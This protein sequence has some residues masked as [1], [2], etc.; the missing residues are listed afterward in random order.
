MDL[1]NLLDYLSDFIDFLIHKIKHF[2]MQ[3]TLNLL[4]LI[5]LG[6]FHFLIV[7][8]TNRFKIHFDIDCYR[9]KI[10]NFQSLVPKDLRIH[11][12][13]LDFINFIVASRILQ[14][15]YLCNL[16]NSQNNCHCY[17]N[18]SNLCYHLRKNTHS[19]AQLRSR[20]YLLFRH[21]KWT[22][23]FHKFGFLKLELDFY[24]PRNFY[25]A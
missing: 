1:V 5:I 15:A 23:I 13:L 12:N 20:E 7:C 18:L 9:E 21:Q 2:L 25:W 3:K 16:L 24:T 22:N 8:L 4:I 17:Q 10:F 14:L 6:V 19:L 11:L